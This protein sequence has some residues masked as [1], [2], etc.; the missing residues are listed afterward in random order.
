MTHPSRR[1]LARLALVVLGAGVALAGS[2]LPARAATPGGVPG[3]GVRGADNGLWVNRGFGWESR[4]GQLLGAPALL[5]ANGSTLYVATGTD[6]SLWV[7]S[8][9]Q[10]WQPL[11][12][13]RP[14]CND[15]PAIDLTAGLFTVAC[16]GGDG[17]LWY[18]QSPLGA[19]LP[20]VG[21]FVSL[22]GA[23]N[24]GPAL[25]EVSG[26]LTF[27]VTGTNRQIWTRTTTTSFSA[28][29][30]FCNGHPGLAASGSQLYFACDGTDGQLWYAENPGNGWNAAQPGGGHL[31]GGVGVAAGPS[32]ADIYVEGTD[33][34]AWHTWLPSGAQTG[35][36][37][38]LGGRIGGG[39][40]A[41]A[42]PASPTAPA[43][44]AYSFS[45]M[46]V[47]GVDADVVSAD[48]TRVRVLTDTAN[49]SDCAS[50]CPVLSVQQF[51]QRNGGFAA[52]NG[53]YFCPYPATCSGKLNAFDSPVYNSR[54]GV[55]INAFHLGDNSRG[56]M[57]FNGSAHATYAFNYQYPR[58]A[59]TA[60]ISMIPDLVVNGQN[61]VGNYRYDAKE[62]TPGLRS[63]IGVAGNHVYLVVAH[64]AST[65]TLAGFFQGIGCTDALHLDSGGSSALTLNGGYVD[66]PGRNVPNAIILAG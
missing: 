3:T 2:P 31:L 49:S 7:R 38:G 54:L 13:T 6:H 25:A 9:D 36:F 61:V 27:M 1:L 15:S 45:H 56:M 5:Y 34:G 48:L 32:G 51:Q 12:S 44:P 57:T 37:N 63:G 30:W 47:N 40:G 16:K 55:W 21:G 22:G 35:G 65:N 8:D 59:V 20:Q 46:V 33:G 58:T 50:N 53:S 62:A 17:G 11:S 23:L 52:I 64:N 29:P 4:G 14:Y 18:A 60:G 66:G 26:T 24:D 39:S 42:G 19:G 41:A 10:G 28:M 43:A